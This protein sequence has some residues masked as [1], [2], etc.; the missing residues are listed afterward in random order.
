LEAI[1]WNAL[2]S[3]RIF[4]AE[5]PVR[6]LSERRLRRY[7]IW[8]FHA[9]R[10]SLRSQ[11]AADVQ[12]DR[13]FIEIAGLPTVPDIHETYSQQSVRLEELGKND[14]LSL[15]IYFRRKLTQ[16]SDAVWIRQLLQAIS[17]WDDLRLEKARETVRLLFE[18]LFNRHSALTQS[19]EP[20]VL[21]TSEGAPPRGKRRQ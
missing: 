5:R 2:E 19:T 21:A 6:E 14:S 18:T 4:E 10:L 1:V 9:C 16:D 7:L 15:A 3:V 11:Q 12:L 8:L 13:V 20:S 17:N